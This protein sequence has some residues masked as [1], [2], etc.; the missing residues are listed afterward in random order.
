M[1]VARRALTPQRARE[2]IASQCFP[3]RIDNQV[4]L[5]VEY[6]VAA[7]QWSVASTDTELAR[8]VVAA[9]PL[10]AQSVVTWEPGGQIELS[11]QPEVDA[12]AAVAAISV[13]HAALEPALAAVGLRLLPMAMEP[14]RLPD[15]CTH[16]ARYDAM[17]AYF[18]ADGTAGRRMMRAS[19]A[20]QVNVG[21]GDGGA[22]DLRWQVAHR[23]GPAMVAA[24]ANSPLAGGGQ[25]GWQSTRLANWF[26]IDPTRT[27]PVVGDHAID[28]WVDAVLAARVMLVKE[29]EHC[30]PVTEHLPFSAWIEGGHPL[31]WPDE[32]DLAYHL[33]TLF[34]PVRPRGWLEVRY[35]DANPHWDVASLVLAALLRDDDAGQAALIAV[36]GTEH[37]WSE[38]A[39]AG[40]RDRDLAAVAAEV[41]GIAAAAMEPTDADAAARCRDFSEQY[42]ARN[43]CP[44]DDLTEQWARTRQP[45]GTST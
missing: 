29:G 25:T 3:A 33:T 38:A 26:L 10:P 30:T 21:M 45:I 11:S 20:L 40:C 8:A 12:T 28:A 36:Q 2:L 37:R 39:R 23:I 4:G 42:P 13:D 32:D 17:E 18:D 19:A 1:A 22:A 7:D 41:V 44:A 31:G 5:E 34:P 15:R 16:A 9:T 35:I 27:A 43:R 24:F 6:L 14:V